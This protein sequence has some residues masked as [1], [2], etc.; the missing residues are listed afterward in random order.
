MRYRFRSL[1][2]AQKKIKIAMAKKFFLASASK[3]ASGFYIGV[4]KGRG[5][6]YTF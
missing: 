6:I 2:S 5:G 1:F 4:Y 3:S